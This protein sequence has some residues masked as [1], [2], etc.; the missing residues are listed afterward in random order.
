VVTSA[1]TKTEA[2][3]SKNKNISVPITIEVLQF[4]TSLRLSRLRL[5]FLTAPNGSH[6]DNSLCSNAFSE[7][8][9]FR[10]TKVD[11]KPR[12]SKRVQMKKVFLQR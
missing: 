7:M 9:V 8:C 5:L 2:T 6:R 4:Q 12:F 3:Y 10:L 1:T 11:E